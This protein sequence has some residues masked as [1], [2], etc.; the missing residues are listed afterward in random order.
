M[1][2]SVTFQVHF[3]SRYERNMMVSVAVLPQGKRIKP[4]GI[5]FLS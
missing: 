3:G 2:S 1:I 5:L 4:H